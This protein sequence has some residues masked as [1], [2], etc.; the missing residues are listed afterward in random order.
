MPLNEEACYVALKERNPE[1]D[2]VFYV[3]H[4]RRWAAATG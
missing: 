4:E 2:G 3:D 1:Y